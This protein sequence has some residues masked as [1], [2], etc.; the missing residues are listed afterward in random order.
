MC[1][2]LNGSSLQR[3][4]LLSA[5][6]FGCVSAAGCD[7]PL[8]EMS[9]EAPPAAATAGERLDALPS[10]LA[11]LQLHGSER[12]LAKVA[13]KVPGFSGLYKDESGGWVV[14]VTNLAAGPEA[15][16]VVAQTLLAEKQSLGL[17]NAAESAPMKVEQA[18][19]SFEQLARWR[20]KVRL[21]MPQ[22]V[23]S[24][25]LDEARGVVSLGVADEGVRA[26]VQPMLQS[27][28]LPGS[29][30]DIYIAPEPEQ[31]T[32][33]SARSRPLI[34]GLEFTWDPTNTADNPLCTI[35]MAARYG[36]NDTGRGFFTASHCSKVKYNS[37]YNALG[38]YTSYYQPSRTSSNRVGYEYV[39][40]A[41]FTGSGTCPAGAKCRYSDA[42]FVL[43]YSNQASSSWG[44]KKIARPQG[45]PAIGGR[46]PNT[47]SS[48]PFDALSSIQLYVG[49]QLHK[50]GRTSGWTKGTLLQTCVD[51]YAGMVSGSP[52]YVVCNDIANTWSEPGDSGSPV[53]FWGNESYNTVRFSGI[54][55]GGPVGNYNETWISPCYG[56]KREYSSY[57]WSC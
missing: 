9:A 51:K 36:Y 29:A 8:A 38:R 26:K 57:D 45:T 32:T 33:L 35:G 2:Q 11:D 16:S 7:S 18:E 25:D 41:P 55:W 21:R 15:A 30:Y 12:E 19:F 23:Y 48:T 3:R 20:D 39:D 17:A 53:F 13:A 54:L 50:V 14:R 37:D 6:V 10:Q 42:A 49:D 4:A 31:R 5:L 27:I 1:P 22:G 40:A 34:A 46:G 24:L 56:I 43:Y 44:G 52:H 28:G 47:L